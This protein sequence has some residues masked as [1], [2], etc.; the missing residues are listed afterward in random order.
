M[1]NAYRA[2]G[3]DAVAGFRTVLTG[4]RKR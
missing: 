2:A 4:L 1:A 3:A